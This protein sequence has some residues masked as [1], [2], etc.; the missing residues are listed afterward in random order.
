MESKVGFGMFLIS[1]FFPGDSRACSEGQS[2][3]VRVCVF[4]I[5]EVEFLQGRH[6]AQ[7]ERGETEG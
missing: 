6:E 3:C 4:W 2:I 7:M 5:E 1:L